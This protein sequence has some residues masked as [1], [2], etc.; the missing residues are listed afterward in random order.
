MKTVTPQFKRKTIQQIQNL[1]GILK[2]KTGYIYPS[3]GHF[4]RE[5]ELVKFP[6]LKNSLSFESKT[7]RN[8]YSQQQYDTIVKHCEAQ[9]WIKIVQNPTRSNGK[10]VIVSRNIK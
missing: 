5:V 10:L 1:K 7:G 2:S 6:Y 9:G 3:M 4:W 8:V